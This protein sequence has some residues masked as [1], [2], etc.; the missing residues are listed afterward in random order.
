MSDQH[1]NL[2][3]ILRFLSDDDKLLSVVVDNRVKLSGDDMD[4][5]E[6]QDFGKKKLS[7]S[8]VRKRHPISDNFIDE[9]SS[10]KSKMKKSHFFDSVITE[11]NSLPQS[12]SQT[13]I[14][15]PEKIREYL[16]PFHVRYGVRNIIEKNLEN[17]NISF[18]NSLN[19][20]LRPELALNGN[21][22]YV[23]NITLLEEMIR[24]RI[25]RNYQIDRLI[26]NTKRVQESNQKVI[27]DLVRGR[28]THE[29]LQ[30]IA[31][32]FEINLVV[33]DLVSNDIILYWTCGSKY[34]FFNLFKDLYF[35]AYI[36]GNYEP[37]III[38]QDKKFD[39]N[40]YRDKV[41]AKLLLDD[42]VQSIHPLKLS[43]FSS[44]KIASLDIHPKKVYD[45]LHKYFNE[46]DENNEE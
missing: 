35:M 42:D 38:E 29:L 1:I 26:K 5:I 7:D 10:K 20:L 44:A 37:I 9:K 6:N 18:L 40:A 11:Y 19:I 34:P 27:N 36:R 33:F 12:E 16:S 3:G 32:I 43:L 45:I 46:D 21:F 8:V 13:C 14:T 22:D 30:Y 15:L 39:I 41:Y 17:V 28:I 25:S 4:S 2:Y 24:H 31:N 23:K